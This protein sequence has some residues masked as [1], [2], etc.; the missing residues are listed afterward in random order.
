V[1]LAILPFLT[2]WFRIAARTTS[3]SFSRPE[4]YL[5]ST[6]SWTSTLRGWARGQSDEL[7][8]AVGQS[9]GLRCATAIRP[10]SFLVGLSVRLIYLWRIAVMATIR[11]LLLGVTVVASSPL[12]AQQA[13]D[14]F[15]FGGDILTMEGKAP[16]YVEALA[17]KDGRITFA[18]ALADADQWKGAGTR[19]INLGGRTLLPGF[20]DGHSHIFL[21]VEG[22]DWAD[23][24]SPPSGAVT[25]FGDI[26]RELKEKQKALGAAPSEWLIGFGYD[27]DLLHEKR[28]PTAADLDKAFPDTPVILLH[29]SGHIFV[30]NSAGLKAKRIDATTPDPAGGVIV[31]LPGSRE[32]SG[33]I[34]E[35]ARFPF[36][37]VLVKNESVDVTA[38]K[39]VK[40]LAHY[41]RH[42]V[43]TVQEGGLQE[44]QLVVA[45]ALAERGQ[46]NLDFVGLVFQ[47]LAEKLIA[48]GKTRW[49]QYEKGVKLAG[50]KLTV[51]GSPQ[52]KTAYLSGHYHT[53]VAGC[54]SDCR[55][56]AAL[57]AN[58]VNE[59]FLLSYR[60]NVQ[61]FAHCNGDAAIDLTLAG[62][63]Y[64]LSQLK[65]TARQKDRR[66]VIVHS[67]IM[68][69]EQLDAYA[70]YGILPSF[71]TNHTYF[72]GDVHL[73]NLGEARA[74]FISPMRSAIDKGIRAA[75]HSDYFV[76]PIDQMFIVWSAVN[77]ITRSGRVLGPEQ[78]ITPY[79]ALQAITLNG[80]YMVFEEN[81]KGSLVP[82][83]LADLVI[84]DRNPLKVDPLSIK[85]IKVVETI[86]A[87]RTVSGG[88][89]KDTTGH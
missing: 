24:S 12:F 21:H 49:G 13:A 88:I 55:G 39:L 20:V 35:N 66:T 54:E 63:E 64:A 36:L 74:S 5:D 33:E 56:V 11:R 15:Y 58:R 25:D 84:L 48:E 52:G 79:E 86:K 44:S 23:L 82:G 80:A 89:Q 4:A 77:R 65:E 57:D 81:E 45:R 47:P 37:D 76:T 38:Q 22:Q 75:N 46:M 72:W 59:L 71:F 60:N 28:H 78:R 41:A 3:R 9:G 10:E 67:Q 69:P 85:D 7:L 26:V 1:S 27:Q 34:Q 73:A 32:P 53:P 40:S 83:K 68:R 8:K 16:R 43:T 18:G 6:R 87:G 50:I 51:D 70:K 29:V 30:V 2:I 31:R 62:H 14:T 19:T 42:G 17:V 61:V